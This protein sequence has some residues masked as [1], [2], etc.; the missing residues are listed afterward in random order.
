MARSLGATLPEHILG[1]EAFVKKDWGKAIRDGLMAADEKIRNNRE[2][3][4]RG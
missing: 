3:I 1:T 4:L 2:W